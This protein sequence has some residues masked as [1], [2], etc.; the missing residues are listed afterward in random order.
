MS[1]VANAVLIARSTMS[2][3]AVADSS[4]ISA[5]EAVIG[6][7]PGLAHSR[8]RNVNARRRI[9]IE[10]GFVENVKI[11][12]LLRRDKRKCQ[13]CGRVVSESG[14]YTPYSI[15]GPLWPTI[16]HIVPLSDGGEHSYRNTQLAHHLCNSL[17]NRGETHVQLRLC[18]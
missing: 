13:L 17:R 18:G 8:H 7:V 4:R 5:T 16:D 12:V 10:R 14:K 9:R 15:C 11:S 1:A 6:S 3:S 2:V